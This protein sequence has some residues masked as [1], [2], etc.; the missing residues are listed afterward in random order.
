VIG[1]QTIALCMIVKDEAST[2]EKC[3]TSARQVIDTWVIVDTGSTDGTPELVDKA[4]AGIPGRLYHRPW[5]DFGANRTEMLELARGAADYLLLLD[6][7]DTISIEGELPAQL[8]EVA[9]MVRRRFGPLDIPVPWLIRGDRAWRYE[10]AVHEYL[11]LGPDIV[12]GQIPALVAVH[13][14]DDPA[15]RREKLRR[16]LDLL[17][18]D[19]RRFPEDPRTTFYVAQTYREIGDYDAAIFW[20]RRRLELDG[21]AEETWYA[22]YQLGNVLVER[23][24]S[25]GVPVLLDAWERRPWRAEP[26]HAI[27]RASRF[28]GRY[29]TARNFATRGLEIPYPDDLLFIHRLIYDWGLLFELSVACYW[30]G[31]YEQA[32]EAND[33]MLAEGKLTPQAETDVR[34]NRE[35]CLRELASRA[36][37][38]T[39]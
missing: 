2:I 15:K 34:R 32:L 28:S 10:R 9:Y 5:R 33:R 11:E 12:P 26:L 23:D 30:V 6:A 16:N 21:W 39:A 38:A 20:Y 19:N 13:H 4:L 31:E 29:H 37:A 14:D 8:D 1:G 22:H 7:D 3:L 18:V 25:A 17:E 27:A 24:W 35:F 36:S